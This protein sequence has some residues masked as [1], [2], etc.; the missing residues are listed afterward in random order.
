MSAALPDDVRDTRT[1]ERRSPATGP[2]F[3]TSQLATQ[4]S[5]RFSGSP[6][7][8]RC[9][10][11]LIPWVLQAPLLIPPVKENRQLLLRPLPVGWGDYLARRSH[12]CRPGW[13]ALVD[14]LPGAVARS[15]VLSP[16]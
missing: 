8:L 16:P 9:P 11:V 12:R 4:R 7:Q 14:H 13:S 3:T 6:A 1:G 2:V 5:D 15:V 10:A